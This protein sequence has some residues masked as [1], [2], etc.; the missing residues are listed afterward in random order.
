MQNYN[1]LQLLIYF[2]LLYFPNAVMSRMY[3]VVY[4]DVLFSFFPLVLCVLVN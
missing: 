2:I 1:L 4:L 3:L